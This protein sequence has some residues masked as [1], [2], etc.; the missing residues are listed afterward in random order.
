MGNFNTTEALYKLW[1]SCILH[2]TMFPPTL[3]PPPPIPLPATYP[4][5]TMQ[6]EQ[7]KTE[8][9]TTTGNFTLHAVNSKH[10]QAQFL[11]STCTNT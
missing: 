2:L 3:N 11:L 1:H 9:K 4:K 10:A 7:K 5:P 8:T 6:V